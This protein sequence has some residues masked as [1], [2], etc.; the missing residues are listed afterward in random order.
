MIAQRLDEA[1]KKAIEFHNFPSPGVVLGVIMFEYALEEL[2]ERFGKAKKLGAMVETWLC[3]PDGVK[4]GSRE[5]YGRCQMKV[6]DFGKMAVTVF[7]RDSGKGVRVTLDPTKTPKFKRIHTWFMRLPRPQ[8]SKRKRYELIG[9]EIL[10]ARR[11]VL[12]ATPVQLRPERKKKEPVVFC[13]ACGEPVTKDLLVGC[14]CKAC[15]GQAYYT[16]LPT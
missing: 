16:A 1:I 8:M 4:I 15:G 13:P 6:V 11:A 10:R 14:V 7:D 3:L 12:T 9:E 5:L 2:L